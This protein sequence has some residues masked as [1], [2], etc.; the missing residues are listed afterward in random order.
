MNS[1]Y[2]NDPIAPNAPMDP[3]SDRSPPEGRTEILPGPLTYANQ[4]VDAD[5]NAYK[6]QIPAEELAVPDLAPVAGKVYV[7]ADP[8]NLTLRNEQDSD[9]PPVDD[10][11]HITY[12]GPMEGSA[13]IK[14]LLVDVKHAARIHELR[15]DI[16]YQAARSDIELNCQQ[17]PE[18]PPGRGAKKDAI[19]WYGV[20]RGNYH[21]KLKGQIEKAVEYLHLIGL[22]ERHPTYSNRVRILDANSTAAN[23]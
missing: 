23:G 22:L 3:S 16:A 1:P 11:V 5:G 14:G 10:T 4:N 9:M 21:P 8:I 12:T 7:S 2:P 20:G 6:E 18:Y 13:M 15:C 17:R 19:M